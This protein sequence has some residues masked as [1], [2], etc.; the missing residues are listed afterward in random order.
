MEAAAWIPG[1]YELDQSLVVGQADEFAFWRV[2]PLHLRAPQRLVFY[3]S[4]WHPE[5]AL[6]ARGTVTAIRH[7]ELGAIRKVDTHGLDYAI[8]LADGNELLVNAEENPG[9]LYERAGEEWRESLRMVSDWR[10]VVELAS[11]SE[12]HA[13]DQSWPKKA[14]DL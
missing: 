12:P 3:N 5:D 11:L 8:T 14:H 4:I 10:L 6:I 2:I 7:P 13:P 1:W 9:K